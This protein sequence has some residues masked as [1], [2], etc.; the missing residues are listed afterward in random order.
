MS[1]RST[2]WCDGYRDA[3]I[4]YPF[5]PPDIDVFA[6]EYRSGYHAAQFDLSEHEWLEYRQNNDL[7]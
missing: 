3:E 6:A 1:N 5:S 4:R 2:F 7:L